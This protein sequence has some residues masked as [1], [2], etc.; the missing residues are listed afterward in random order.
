LLQGKKTLGLIPARG[1]SKR[2]LGKNIASF[3][4]RPL[5]HW[6]IDAVEKS[7][8]LAKC[9]VSTDCENIAVTVM[10][11]QSEKVEIIDRSPSLAQDSTVMEDV[12]SSVLA[13]LKEKGEKYDYVMLLQPTSPFR[14]EDHIEEA[15]ALMA[16]KETFGV[17]SV[18]KTEH[19]IEWMGHLGSNGVMDEFFAKESAR[20]QTQEL[21]PSYLING[22]IYIISVEKFL[23]YHTLAL[24]NGMVAY[25]MGREE[26]VDIDYEIDLKYAEWLIDVGAISLGS[27]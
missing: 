23:K 8:S 26:S 13:T 1:G 27:D 7:Q 15:L 25:V 16:Q 14:N 5:I 17:V 6:T 12:V 9:V 10:E 2:F 19:P 22:A 11:H 3:C 18:C 20:K 21:R 4:G 24:P